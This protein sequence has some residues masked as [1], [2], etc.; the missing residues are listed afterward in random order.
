MRVATNAAA[1]ALIAAGCNGRL[2]STT[3]PATFTLKPDQSATAQG[4]VVTF[5]QVVSD[6]RC[7]INAMCVWAGEATVA[8]TVRRTGQEARYELQMTPLDV[9]KRTVTHQGVTI[10]FQALQPHPVGGQP[11]DRDSYRLTIEIR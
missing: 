6:S 9:S 2:M 1:L 4:T 11:T 8:I 5:R 10:E 7:P 3:L